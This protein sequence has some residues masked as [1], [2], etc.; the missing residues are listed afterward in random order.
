[1]LHLKRARRLNAPLTNVHKANVLATGRF[2]NSVVEDVA[3]EYSDVRYE[4]ILVDNAAF[5]ISKE[6]DAV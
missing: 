6:S 3:Q 1:M 5:S 4:S 2:W